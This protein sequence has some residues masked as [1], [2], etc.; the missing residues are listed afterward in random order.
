MHNMAQ[1]VRICTADLCREECVH[2]LTSCVCV[3]TSLPGD[4]DTE[5]KLT[6]HNVMI[7]VVCFHSHLSDL[8][9]KLGPVVYNDPLL[10]MELD[11]L[12]IAPPVIA[13]Y[14]GL[15]SFL[16][17][18]EDFFVIEDHVGLARD[19]KKCQEMFFERNNR[20][21]EQGLPPP[22]IT[23]IGFGAQPPRTIPN[24]QIGGNGS[25]PSLAD[26]ARNNGDMVGKSSL[27]VGHNR[28]SVGGKGISDLDG[29]DLPTGG[30]GGMAGS[31]NDIDDITVVLPTAGK[32][33]SVVVNEQNKLG[34]EKVVAS[35]AWPQD[36]D[37][38]KELDRV[39]A[40]QQ[41]PLDGA[42]AVPSLQSL[43]RAGQPFGGAPGSFAGLNSSGG[44][45]VSVSVDISSL[46]TYDSGLG[47]M[48]LSS[49]DK[50]LL[51]NGTGGTSSGNSSADAK[52]SDAAAPSVSVNFTANV[53]NNT[54]T[55]ANDPDAGLTA[56][57]QGGLVVGSKG[58]LQSEGSSVDGPVHGVNNGTDV[59][60]KVVKVKDVS[61]GICTDD[62]VTVTVSTATDVIMT[63]AED[64]K[65]VDSSDGAVVMETKV[66]GAEVN[67]CDKTAGRKMSGQTD[68]S[69]GV[70]GDDDE[71]DQET[72]ALANGA[73]S[74]KELAA[75]RAEHQ[76][77]QARYKLVHNACKYFQEKRRNMKGVVTQ[78]LEEAKVK[79]R[80]M[81]MNTE[82]FMEF[83]E[84]KVT[85][86]RL[87]VRI[88]RLN[89][90]I[91]SYF[92]PDLI[93]ICFYYI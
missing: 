7:H 43:S 73:G 41:R 93:H 87:Q 76:K 42:G 13:R 63:S 4:G 28:P 26:L 40:S 19:S 21:K 62:D 33:G 67:I 78:T 9:D 59:D 74:E 2:T 20:L 68:H 16:L 84:L 52:S 29:F 24:F 45:S 39:L 18:S 60:G 81:G 70:G 91:W 25:E 83:E 17:Q 10:E 11:K 36:Q 37:L 53:N 54:I 48:G 46:P 14:G 82:A 50:N 6:A 61:D 31:M 27:V 1:L 51:Q 49:V 79:T 72:S 34:A 77:L 58:Q 8:F 5:Y 69:P 88:W 15:C 66:S 23:G 75:L 30:N 85:K 47:S 65:V 89:L 55:A 71:E 32:P 56:A 22:P 12:P 57:K 35:G 44:K 64:I 90:H 38:D 86:D 92:G 80:S 3:L